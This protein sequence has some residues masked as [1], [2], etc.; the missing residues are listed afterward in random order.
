MMTDLQEFS[1]QWER[2]T[3]GTLALMGALPPKQYDFRPDAGGRSL[4]ELAWHLAEVSMSSRRTSNAPGRS[5]RS[6]VPFVL[7]TKTRSS[8]WLA[9]GRPTWIERSDTAEELF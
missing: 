8:E 7:C 2:E 9:S 1:R 6:R 5:M 3:D 4:G